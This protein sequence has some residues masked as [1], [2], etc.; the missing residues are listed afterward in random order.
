[1]AYERVIINDLIQLLEN[2]SV[3]DKP[4]VVVAKFE[5]DDIA[6]WS[7]GCS[8]AKH[9]IFYDPI[10]DFEYKE[11]ERH[12]ILTEVEE[13]YKQRYWGLKRVACYEVPLTEITGENAYDI[14]MGGFKK[15]RMK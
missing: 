6:S 10:Y 4:M 7:K 12:F 11:F 3:Y 1:M 8:P 5:Y 13:S 14:I 2:P 9:Y 15:L